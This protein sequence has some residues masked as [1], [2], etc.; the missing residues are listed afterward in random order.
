MEIRHEGVGGNMQVGSLVRYRNDAD[1]GIVTEIDATGM[2][3]I[4]WSDG[5]EGWHL[6]SEMEV[7]CK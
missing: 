6:Q 7:I 3:H 1:L 4:K 5:K 2:Y